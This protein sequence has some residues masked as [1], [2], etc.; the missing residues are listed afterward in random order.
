MN[1]KPTLVERQQFDDVGMEAPI[2]Q[3]LEFA[4]LS[5]R[6]ELFPNERIVK[7][8][9][10]FSELFH[11]CTEAEWNDF[12]LFLSANGVRQKKPWWAWW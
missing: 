8:D 2:S 3:I 4:L 6:V 7:L 11:R 9:I 1:K 10:P 5:K 12:M